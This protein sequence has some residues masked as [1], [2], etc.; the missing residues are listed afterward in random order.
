MKIELKNISK[1]FKKEKVLDDISYT[2]NEKRIYGIAAP[3]KCGNI[4]S[5]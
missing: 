5:C 3:I 4:F 2:F 1:S